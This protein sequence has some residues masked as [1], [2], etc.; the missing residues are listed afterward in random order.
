MADAPLPLLKGTLDVLVLKALTWGPQH[1]FGIAVWLEARSGGVLGVDDSALYQALQRMEE[2][3]LVEAEWGMTENNRRARFYRMTP[4]GRRQLR[5]QTTDW[6][7]YAGAV[8]GILSTATQR[9]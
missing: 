7:R 3:G 1:G 4:A 6:L 5:A 2:R 9:A 8:T